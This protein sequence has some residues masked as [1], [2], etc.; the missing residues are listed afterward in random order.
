M[1][2]LALV[3]VFILAGSFLILKITDLISPMTVSNEE[4]LIGSDFSQH[5]E[6]LHPYEAPK[7]MAA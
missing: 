7:E 5:G 3:L 1:I 6:N 4:K 2:A